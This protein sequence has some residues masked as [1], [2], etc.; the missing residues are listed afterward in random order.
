MMHPDSDID[1]HREIA[2]ESL[3]SDTESL[4]T[5]ETAALWAD[6]GIIPP[7][8]VRLTVE[9]LHRLLIEGDQVSFNDKNFLHLFLRAWVSAI[10]NDRNDAVTVIQSPEN[11]HRFAAASHLDIARE[12]RE[13]ADMVV[14]SVI[15]DYM[16]VF[17]TEKAPQRSD[18]V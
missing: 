1:F 17:L 5:E 12:D 11:L 8:N 10:T 13:I 4:M 9:L 16:A 3:I 14:R 7:E 2:G 15:D 6:A 18:V